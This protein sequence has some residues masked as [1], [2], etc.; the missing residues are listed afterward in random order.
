M[1]KNSEVKNIGSNYTPDGKNL[2]KLSF[3]IDNI[4]H[5][6]GQ[7]LTVIDASLEGEK[8]EAVKDLIKERFSKK[9][10]WFCEVAW[11][12]VPQGQN[13]ANLKTS[14]AMDWFVGVVSLDGI[15]SEKISKTLPR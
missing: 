9:Q 8:R 4:S 2:F 6:L 13:T 1:K 10:D 15:K 7:T 12:D 3:I 5:L 14:P 11:Y